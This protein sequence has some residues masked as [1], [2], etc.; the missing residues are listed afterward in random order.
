MLENFSRSEFKVKV[1]T[2]LNAVIVEA[3]ILMIWCRD[4]LV[5][6][7]VKCNSVCAFM[8]LIAQQEEHVFSYSS[9]QKWRLWE[10]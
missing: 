1:M 4:L 5:S 6:I 2:R 9:C 7:T 10:I 3:C 8:L